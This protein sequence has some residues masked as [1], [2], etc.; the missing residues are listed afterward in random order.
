MNSAQPHSSENKRKKQLAT[1][2]SFCSP[3]PSYLSQQMANIKRQAMAC[4]FVAAAYSPTRLVRC[5]Q[6]AIIKI[7][8]P[9]LLPGSLTASD[10]RMQV[11]RSLYHSKHSKKTG[12]KWYP[13]KKKLSASSMAGLFRPGHGI[14]S[15]GQSS[16]QFGLQIQSRL[17]NF[18][19][20]L[21]NVG[22]IVDDCSFAVDL[23]ASS[24][25]DLD[26]KI[27]GDRQLTD[28]QSML[29]CV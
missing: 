19:K 6:S 2:L 3:S 17:C 10:A 23:V 11:L 24:S 14:T 4:V 20:R 15:V 8:I 13:A 5:W 29:F 26:P 1:I 22:L 25:E 18:M 9:P 28:V 7:P 12:P 27:T 16:G 21:P